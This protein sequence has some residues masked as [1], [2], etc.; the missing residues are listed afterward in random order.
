MAEICRLKACCGVLA[1]QQILGSV[2][3]V[4]RF[5]YQISRRRVSTLSSGMNRPA[6]L[7]ST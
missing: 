2:V 7:P 3:E 6:V 4:A 1:L 5:S